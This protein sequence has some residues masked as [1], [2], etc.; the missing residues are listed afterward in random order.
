MVLV[1][2]N[3]LNDRFVALDTKVNMFTNPAVVPSS[4]PFQDHSDFLLPGVDNHMAWEVSETPD[5]L[6]EPPTDEELT[7]FEKE[8]SDAMLS[9]N[10]YFDLQK[11]L[12]AT[13]LSPHLHDEFPSIMGRFFHT[14]SWPESLP[15]DPAH[16]TLL[17]DSWHS[18][19]ESATRARTKDAAAHFYLTLTNASALSNPPAFECFL[20]KYIAFC[21][22]HHINAID[23]PTDEQIP[24]LRNF[25]PP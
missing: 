15:I 6:T 17:R 14:M 23:G 25:K 10:F 8:H 18:H 4:Q 11:L 12:D 13:N 16:L 24:W 7:A 21:S 1:A 19:V 22:H 2:L 5:A 9:E 3:N 20:T